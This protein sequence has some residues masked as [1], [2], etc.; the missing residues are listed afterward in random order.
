MAKQVI[1]MRKDLKMKKGKSVAQGAHAS[2]GVILQMLNNGLNMREFPPEVKDNKYTLSM[3][4]EVG[5]DLDDWLMGVFR[6]VCLGVQ[7]EE[8]LMEIYEK[9]LEANLP[10]SLITDS[11]LTVFNGVKTTTCLAIGP[12][13]EEAID[14]LTGHLP[15]Y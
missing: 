7:S 14:A 12:A 2:L 5:S 11:G 15:L 3:E 10:V 6:K 9:A 8:E 4:V 1:V 13:N